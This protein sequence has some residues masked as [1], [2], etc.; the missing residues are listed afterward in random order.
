MRRPIKLILF[1]RFQAVEK[2]ALI[3]TKSENVEIKE[4]KETE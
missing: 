1:F 4:T 3:N 2:M